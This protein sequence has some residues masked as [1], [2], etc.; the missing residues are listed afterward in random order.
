MN[1]RTLLM[2]GGAAILTIAAALILK[3]NNTTP[4]P[5]GSA[6]LAFPNLAQRL[7]GA[8][9]IEVTRNADGVVVQRMGE[10]WV[11]PERGNYPARP[12][13]VRELLTGLT[14]LRLT[15]PR[16]ANPELLDRLGVNDPTQPGSTAALVRVLNAQGAPIAQLVVGRRRVR[17]QGNV[18][19]AAFI[20]RA[21]ENQAWL[22]EGRLPIDGD[23]GLWLDRGIAAIPRDRVLRVAIRRTD[24]PVLE[25]A[26]AGEVDAPLRVTN[27]AETPPLDETSLDEIGRAFESLTFVE[28]TADTVAHGTDIGEARFTL[29]DN[30]TLVA[31][32]SRDG[33]AIW[34]RF[35]AEGDDE[36]TRLNARW[37]GWAFQIGQWKEKAFVPL[38]ADLRRAEEP[39]AE[40]PAAAPLEEAPTAATPDLPAADAPAP[41]PA[42]PR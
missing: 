29:T 33:E 16:T 25:L 22:A 21:G 38:L 32:I 3:P 5:A 19:E 36:A 1:Q 24:A 12:D 9:R 42:A 37:R 26:R 2:L 40:A 10:T 6:E 31:R 11:L 30:L 20:R 35:A 15:E 41:A 4:P 27:P 23:A 34:A 13:R 39:P 14:E 7:Q 8:A 18:P 17:T 28:V